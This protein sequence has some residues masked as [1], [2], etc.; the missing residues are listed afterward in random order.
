MKAPLLAACFVFAFARDVATGPEA[1][2]HIDGWSG[3]EVVG[4]RGGG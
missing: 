1:G 3:R 2:L 4:S